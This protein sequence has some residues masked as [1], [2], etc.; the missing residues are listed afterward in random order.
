MLTEPRLVF[1]P[2]DYYEAYAFWEQQQQAHW[3]H[4]EVSMSAD[5]QDFKLNLT[6]SER[7]VIGNTLKGFAQTEVCVQDYWRRVAAWFPKP[8]VAMMCAAFS[9]METVHAKAYA[10][11]NETLGLDDFAA[12]LQEPSAKAKIDALIDVP[13]GSLESMA[14]SLAVFSGFAEGVQLFSSFAILMNFQRFN[15][16]KGIGQIVAFSIRDESLH[17]T[18]GCWLFRTLVEENPELLSNDLK[19][20]IY[21]AARNAVKMEDAFIKQVFEL[22][23]VEGLDPKDLMVYIRRRANT[24]LQDLGFKMNWKN[25]DQA[26]LD[27]LDWFEDVA[28]G[29]EQQDFFAHRVSSYSKGT[30]DFSG[31]WSD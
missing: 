21:D 14:R 30:A 27:R 5:V 6:D 8:E 12:F 22:G 24:R 31:I 9:N 13:D 1:E 28:N 4:V 17:S 3:L 26:A 15:K 11:L 29:E 23:P 20:Q 19:R 25:L 18:A 10:Y 2:F 16:L 7:Q